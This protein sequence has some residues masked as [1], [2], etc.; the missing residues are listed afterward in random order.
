[1]AESIFG[2]LESEAFRAGIPARTEESRRW[3]MNKLKE[4]G[5]VNRHDLLKDDLVS[6][7]QRFGIGNMY[8]FFYDPK[9]RQTLPYYDAFPLIV[10]VKPAPGGFYGLNLHYL[11]PALRAK[12]LDAL[13]ETKT[14]KQYNDSTK[15][16]ATYKMLQNTSRLRY[17][18]PC[19]KHYLSKH[20]DSKIA[21]VHSPEWEIA[22]FMPSEQF[23]KA[24]ARRVWRDSRKMI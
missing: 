15:F 8:M 11:P 16:A 7:R 17:Y 5:S 9:H 10:A 4:L 6:S 18:K 24:N 20:I 1:M 14:N 21:L 13:L 23:R 2:K 12:M 22:T 3:F 19:F